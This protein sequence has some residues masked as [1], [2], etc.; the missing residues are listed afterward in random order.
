MP[1]CV[2]GECGLESVVKDR[3]LMSQAAK[4]IPSMTG[5]SVR[6]HAGVS[7]LREACGDGVDIFE[8]IDPVLLLRP[9]DYEA[10]VENNQIFNQE[11]LFGYLANADSVN[12]MPFQSMKKIAEDSGLDMRIL[13]VHGASAVVPKRYR[14][15]ASPTDFVRC[16]RDAKYVITNSFHGIC[17]S[18]IFKKQFVYV[19]QM[20]SSG[21]REGVRQMEMLRRCGLESRYA[22][23]FSIG[24]I[25]ACMAAP[26][27]WPAVGAKLES[28]I[29]ASDNWL[30]NILLDGVMK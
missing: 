23:D 24:N 25:R 22:D 2:C 10:V 8:A 15:F 9:F 3:G 28:V 1:Y 6:E 14:V 29:C 30:H 20:S 17:F 11:T 16:F 7:C 12:D 21:P 5:V 19:R 18:V 13:G 4:G 26:I 27:D